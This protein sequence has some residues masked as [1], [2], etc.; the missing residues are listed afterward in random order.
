MSSQA[1]IFDLDGTLL[2]S[3]DDL[4]DS[5]NV[6]LKNKGFP[7]HSMESYRYFIGEGARMLLVRALP[8]SQR[9]ENTI[10]ECLEA[11]YQCY[12]KNW[13]MK[14]KPYAGVDSVLNELAS[15]EIKMAIFSNKPHEFVL[16][17]VDEW[18]SNWKFDAILGQQDSLPRKPDPAGAFQISAQ[19]KMRPEQFLYFGD[20]GTDMQTAS[21]ANMF[22][23]GVLWGFRPLEELKKMGA[24]AVIEKPEEI[25]QFLD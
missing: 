23:V 15:R 5:V 16:Q 3:L 17:F 24:K 1:I 4:G 10:T 18:L 8:E 11:F 13:N 9:N 6:V 22:P 12:S 25:L 2:D 7:T 21:A 20:S 19:L 14:T